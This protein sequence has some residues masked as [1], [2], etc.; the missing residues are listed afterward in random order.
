MSLRG[1]CL[2]VGCADDGHTVH[3]LPMIC[4]CKGKGE[5]VLVTGASLPFHESTRDRARCRPGPAPRQPGEIFL[6]KIKPCGRAPC[7]G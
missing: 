5:R 4:T 6:A 1:P 3:Q 2:L 7:Q